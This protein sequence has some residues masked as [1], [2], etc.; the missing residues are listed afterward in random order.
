MDKKIMEKRMR[1]LLAIDQNAYDIYTS[2]AGRAQTE[3]MK[4]T[5]LALAADEKKH[6]KVENEILSL[7]SK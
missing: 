6:V 5:L 3:K 4:N 7:I 2:L 1:Q